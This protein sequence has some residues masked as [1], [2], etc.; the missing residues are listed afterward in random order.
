MELYNP[1]TIGFEI[2]LK[3]CHSRNVDSLQSVA[4]IT[5]PFQVQTHISKK[6]HLGCNDSVAI[7]LYIDLR[8]HDEN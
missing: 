5:L 3:S 1:R 7:I 2:F 8:D 6:Y 4:K